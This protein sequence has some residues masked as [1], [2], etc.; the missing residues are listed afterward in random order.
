MSTSNATG[1]WVSLNDGVVIKS[2]T[3]G[4]TV[5]EYEGLNGPATVLAALT[6]TGTQPPAAPDNSLRLTPR[7]TAIPPGR[8]AVANQIY[9]YPYPIAVFDGFAMIDL[10]TGLPDIDLPDAIK[11][12]PVLWNFPST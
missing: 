7:L 9:F 8:V 6:K 2:L 1:P 3:D 12:T 10:G 4:F 11:I 5:T